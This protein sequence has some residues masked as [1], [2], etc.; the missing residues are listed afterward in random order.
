MRSYCFVIHPPYYTQV[1]HADGKAVALHEE[2]RAMAVRLV[3][4]EG[5]RERERERE[6]EKEREE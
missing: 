3:V 2:C 1:Q 6:R 4:R 5:Q